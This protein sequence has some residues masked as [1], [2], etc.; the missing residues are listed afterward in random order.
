[1]IRNAA[2]I[3]GK[4]SVFFCAC[5]SGAGVGDGWRVGR[6]VYHG[7]MVILGS[8]RDVSAFHD[9]VVEWVCRLI[10]QEG[11]AKYGES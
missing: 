2:D 3:L 11:V 7:Y 4:M 8:S 9:F 1:M 6:Y 5:A 10:K